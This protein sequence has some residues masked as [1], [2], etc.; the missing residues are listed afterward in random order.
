MQTDKLPLW[1]KFLGYLFGVGLLF[2]GGRFLLVPEVAEHGFGL[3]YGQPTNAFHYIK[4]IRD[5]FSGLVITIFTVAGWRK[6][7]A[8]AILA[9]SLIPLVDMLIVLNAPNAVAG[10]E[11]IHGLT[12]VVAWVFGYFLIRPQP[13]S[14]HAVTA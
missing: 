1:A 8:V 10:A 4:G 13:A 6:P 11:W 3:V 12:A 14:R 2:I 5:I 9:G 7:L